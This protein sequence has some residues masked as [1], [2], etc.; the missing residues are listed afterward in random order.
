[1]FFHKKPPHKSGCLSFHIIAMGL[2]FVTAVASFI[3]LIL[4]HYDPTDQMLVFGT[5]AASLAIMA[6]GLNVWLLFK[7]CA[8]CMSSCDVCAMPMATKKK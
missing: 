5:P 2:L 6:F 7:M 1:M 4:A 3:G 8:S